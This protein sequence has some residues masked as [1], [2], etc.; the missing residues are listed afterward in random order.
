MQ[1]SGTLGWD[2]GQTQPSTPSCSH[3][4]LCQLLSNGVRVHSDSGSGG[5]GWV[6]EGEAGLK[7]RPRHTLPHAATT[8]SQPHDRPGRV[9]GEPLRSL[10]S[11][12]DVAWEPLLKA[13]SAQTNWTFGAMAFMTGPVRLRSGGGVGWGLLQVLICHFH[14][15]LISTDIKP[16]HNKIHYKPNTNHNL[17]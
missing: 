17:K 13:P 7:L 14:S 16:K 5:T 1:G 12:E 2:W 11:S 6:S 10:C 15:P 9:E 3:H 8:T 4:Y